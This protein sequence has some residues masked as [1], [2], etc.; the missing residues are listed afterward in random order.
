MLEE[1]HDLLELFLGFV[2]AGDIVEGGLGIGLDI[3]LGLAAPDRHESARTGTLSNATEPEHPQTKEQ[4]RRDD[5]GQQGRQEAALNL[6]AE[7]DVIALELAREVR[8]HAGG[9][10]A[11]DAVLLGL[12]PVALDVV[13]R[14]PDVL[15]FPRMQIV[16]ELAV[17]NDP[18]A[19]ARG[20]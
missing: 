15:D 13:A 9:H 12:F 16:E 6:A 2:N 20:P 17:G 8:R 10:K 4:Q 3:D 19:L 1:F 11:P 5:P 14:N 7:A 18:G